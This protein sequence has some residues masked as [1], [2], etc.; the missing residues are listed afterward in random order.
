MKTIKS[1]FLGTLFGAFLMSNISFAQEAF[2]PVYLT[3]TTMHRNIDSDDDWVKTEQ[4]YFDKVTSKNDLIIGSEVLTHYYTANSTEVIFVYVYKTWEDILKSGQITSDLEK[5]AWPDEKTRSAFMDKQRNNFTTFHSDEIYSTLQGDKIFKPTSKEPMVVYVRVSQMA[6]DGQ[7]KGN[8]EYN[9]NV[10]QKNPLIKGYYADR[11]AWGADSRDLVEAF[12]YNSLS[13]LEKS[14]DE[15]T[16]LI[17]AAWPKEDDRKAFF[18]DYNKYTT[19]IHRD[20][21][22]T[23]VPSLRK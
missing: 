3:A 12:Y 9:A 16:K 18:K 7:G 11:H 19:G 17:E 15:N 5:K 10:I 1:K 20:Y 21:I 4:E 2:T 22:Y 6:M 14:S 23:N 13:D 8:K